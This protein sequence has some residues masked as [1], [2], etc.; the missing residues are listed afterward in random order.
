MLFCL[1]HGF[2]RRGRA[3][4]APARGFL[5]AAC[6]LL[7]VQA[8]G[9]TRVPA[10]RSGH[11]DDISVIQHV[12]FIVKENRSFD[13]YFGTYPGA[14]GA[15]TAVIST[16]QTISL[17]RTPDPMPRDL[18]H[19]WFDAHTGM[20]NGSMDLFDILGEGSINGDL[21][22]MSQLTQ[23][24]IPN[25]F[26][27]AQHFVLGDN[28][29]SSLA[30]ASFANH[31]YTVSAQ[32][33]NVFGQADLLNQNA[34]GCDA[35]PEMYVYLWNDDDTV[36]TVFP[37]FTFETLADEMLSAGV[38]W[39]YYASPQGLSGYSYSTLDDFSA[40]RYGPGW[41]NVVNHTQFNSDALSGNLPEVSWLMAL[42]GDDDHPP[43]AACPGENWAVNTLNA[44]MN[45]PDWNSTAVFI[46]WD[47]FGGFY[48]HVPPP[49]LDKFGLGP[50]VPLLIISPYAIAGYISHTQY[51]ASSV[52]KFVEERFGLPPLAERD[53][54]ANDMT[55][56]FNFSQNPI[57]PYILSPRVCPFITPDFYSGVQS[58]GG[59][60]TAETLTF[61]N[62]A[63]KALTI[64]SIATTG[65]FS[66][67]NTC[68]AKLNKAQ[69]CNINLAFAPTATG[70]RTGTL[71]ITDSDPSSPQ[72]SNLTGTGTF[73]S[74]TTPKNFG[75]VIYGAKSAQAMTLTNTG[76]AAL[77]ISSITTRGPFTES[78]NCSGSVVA[79]GS[80]QLTLS[81]AP[82]TSGIVYGD[83]IVNATDP[84]SPVM[85][86]FSGTGKAIRF[87][88]GSLTF[89]SQPVGTTSKPQNIKVMN[90]S[91]TDN[92]IMGAVTA[93]GDFAA[94]S[95]CPQTLS[96]AASCTIRVTFTP[97]QTGVRTGAVTVIDSDFRS[98]QV[99][100]L[101]GTGS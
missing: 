77:A 24:D 49:V 34:W 43:S 52:L 22:S 12:V 44:I 93:A 45:G 28:T 11:P 58:V 7:G 32:S 55:D 60:S 96:P 15:T 38:S 39:R 9:Q 50:R 91:T 90:P 59:T 89:A 97:T 48:D 16:G 87:T 6:V 54:I 27:Y 51:E 26:N 40:I 101:T 88:P 67:T 42:A 21:L 18:G 70:P 76:G 19:A 37:C 84:A 78:D 25:Y 4:F 41:S 14:N 3:W 99:L 69:S 20:D 30:G 8:F 85:I 46:L 10:P 81:F 36:N 17:L 64:S 62:Q 79:G 82:T 53:A 98:P 80:C 63:S 31:L 29:F 2:A 68:P 47:D 72:V 5:L 23:A 1:L 86:N 71:T 35:T 75:T 66:Q 100:A 83:V 92:L 56:S 33:G 73:I 95:N 61:V 57:A 94:E 65:D 74:L 13:N